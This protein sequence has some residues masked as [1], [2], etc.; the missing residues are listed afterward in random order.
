MITPMRPNVPVSTWGYSLGSMVI[1]LFYRI[2]PDNEP[3]ASL[4]AER[5]QSSPKQER[6]QVHLFHRHI[7]RQ[8]P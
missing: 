7:S 6:F 5:A 2:L 3:F 4:L 8:D 1:L